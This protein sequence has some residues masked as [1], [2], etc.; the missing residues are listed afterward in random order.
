[1]CPRAVR[2]RRAAGARL[3]SWR[4]EICLSGKKSWKSSTETLPSGVREWTD[5]CVKS[6]KNCR[7][8]CPAP[9]SLRIPRDV[10]QPPGRAPRPRST[11]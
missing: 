3:P 7:T 11:P 8:V 1:M 6:Y 4:F 9:A 10:L 2:R 5:M